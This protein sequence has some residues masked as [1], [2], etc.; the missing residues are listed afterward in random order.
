VLGDLPYPEWES[1]H[2][3]VEPWPGRLLG[4][5][6]ADVLLGRIRGD[7]SE[8]RRLVLRGDEPL[9]AAEPATAVPVS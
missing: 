5:R 1:E 4:V 9:D 3:L 2:V 7:A 6:A 8:P